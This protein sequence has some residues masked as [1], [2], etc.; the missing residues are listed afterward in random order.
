MT[1]TDTLVAFRWN[2]KYLHHIR[3]LAHSISTQRGKSTTYSDLIREAL[4]KT[5]P[6]LNK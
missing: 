2:K 6:E 5:Y 4:D 3:M 1:K